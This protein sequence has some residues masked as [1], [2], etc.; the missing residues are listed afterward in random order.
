MGRRSDT[1]TLAAVA[2]CR[3]VFRR[4]K[5]EMTDRDTVARHAARTGIRQ[6]FMQE[7]GKQEETRKAC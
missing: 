5:A 6:E 4:W 2:E 7:C 1:T 3:E